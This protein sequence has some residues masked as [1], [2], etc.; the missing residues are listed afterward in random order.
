[1]QRGYDPR[2]YTL[3]AFGGA[4]P[5]HAADLADDLEIGTVLIPPSPGIA[6]ARGLLT[7]DIQYDNQVTI[8][9]RLTDVPADT[10]VERFERLVARGTRQ[11]RDDGIDPERATFRQ[12]LDCLYEGQGYELNVAFDS[13]EG[14]WRT[15][16][17]DRFEAK[18]EAEYGHYFEADPVELLNLR[19]AAT[20]GARAYDP[21][22]IPSSEESPTAARTGTERIVFGTSLNPVEHEVPRYD[23]DRLRASQILQGPA[24]VDEFDSTVVVSPGWD[25]TVLADGSLQLRKAAA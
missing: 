21:P 17:R 6:S 5:M 23:R 4:G 12:S 25:A 8:S 1:M 24:I 19:V 2:E 9:Q 16:L 11:L 22:T 7:G 13:T 15:R 14:D 3:V 10:V 18:H 20:A